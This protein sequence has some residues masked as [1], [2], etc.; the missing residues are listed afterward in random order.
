MFIF[1]NF[2]DNSAIRVRTTAARLIRLTALEKYLKLWDV[3]FNNST[4]S[5][6]IKLHAVAVAAGIQKP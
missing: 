3:L 4:S 5:V 2:P 6:G 1:S